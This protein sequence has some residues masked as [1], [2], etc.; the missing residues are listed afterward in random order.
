[1][2]RPDGLVDEPDLLGA[3]EG[4]ALPRVHPAALGIQPPAR[5]DVERPRVAIVHDIRDVMVLGQVQCGCDRHLRV[6]RGHDK[7]DR[8]GGVDPLHGLLQ[9]LAPGPVDLLG[10]GPL[11]QPD[12]SLHPGPWRQNLEQA[13]E[14]IQRRVGAGATLPQ[15]TLDGEDGHVPPIAGERVRG[16]HGTVDTAG[17]TGGEAPCHI[18][19]VRSCAP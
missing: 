5:E 12:T 11:V 1:V 7:V 4:P 9:V 3:L 2:P 17:A 16:R 8:M 14:R 13:V 19:Q 6:G 10:E 15:V 18:E